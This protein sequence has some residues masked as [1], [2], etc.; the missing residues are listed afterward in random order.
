M[1]NK[2][3]AK[4]KAIKSLKSEMKEDAHDMLDDLKPK[5]MVKIMADSPEGIKEG[6]EKVEELMEGEGGIGK[7]LKEAF[8]KRSKKV[9]KED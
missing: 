4:R 2:L 5:M 3:K 8:E 7:L 6:A 1:A 9:K